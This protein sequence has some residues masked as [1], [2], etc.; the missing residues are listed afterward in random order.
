MGMECQVVMIVGSTTKDSESELLLNAQ[1][2]SRP[3]ATLPVHVGFSRNY[4]MYLSALCDSYSRLDDL[5]IDYYTKAA[6][7]LYQ[8]ISL[9]LKSSNLS[10]PVSGPIKTALDRQP[11]SL[12][13]LVPI[14]P[15]SPRTTHTHPK[16]DPGGS[17]AVVPSSST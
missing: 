6:A 3:I 2:C 8:S 15:L 16:D 14:H 9:T 12:I 13:G 4:D 17:N 1:S 7:E 10:E 5:V 11:I